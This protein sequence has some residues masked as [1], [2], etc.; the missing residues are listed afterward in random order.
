MPAVQRV[1]RGGEIRIDSGRGQKRQNTIWR[2]WKRNLLKIALVDTCGFNRSSDVNIST[3]AL[4][5]LLAPR[6]KKH[7]V[8]LT[9]VLHFH[10]YFEG[11]VQPLLHPALYRDD[12]S[13]CE[14]DRRKLYPGQKPGR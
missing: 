13:D 10:L 12:P 4:H 5:R 9:Q 3:T 14:N 8:V 6:P 1:E 2:D 11:N 7:V